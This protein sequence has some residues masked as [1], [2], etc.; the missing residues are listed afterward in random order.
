[1]FEPNYRINGKIAKALMAIEADRQVVAGL[2]LTAP[3]LDSLRRT[4]RL[5]STHFSTQIE[6]NQLTASQVE[7][8][9]EGEGNFPGRERDEAE[10]RHYFAAM[11]HVERLGRTKAALT[12]KDIRTIHG[13]VMT[14]KPK[15]T[16]YRDGQ[17]VIRD[18]RSGRTVYMPPEAKDVP[19]LM[20]D[21]VRWVSTSL[22]ARELPA[23]VVAALAHYQFATIH[24]YFDGNGRTARLLTTL[25]LH[26]SGYG[27]KGIYSLEE[28]YAANL[29][30]YYAGLSVGTSHNYYFG[31]A[32]GDVTPF[33]EYF[34]V[35]MADAFGKVRSR[36]EEASRSQGTDQSLA[37]RNL[38]P[39]QRN[40]LGLFRRTRI[41]TSK[42]VATYFKM[43][44][45]M[46]RKLCA[47]WVKEKFLAV[48]NPS[49]KGRKYR[50]A[51]RYES[52]L[53]A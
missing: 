4:A 14:G 49:T 1:M 16:P 17:N 25:L 33:V 7:K 19:A 35:G 37:L 41:V 32:E 42:D 11:E 43:K 47:K 52:L 3:M 40:A 15:A 48:E 10:V 30:G 24:P 28:Y 21:L 38:S 9:V 6:G 44:P 20:K 13:L 22:D 53:S 31:R 8:V 45:R 27:L 36:A 2:P 39:Q 29:D 18:A 23:P 12:E 50:L 34:C 5:L 26:R 46:A 51:D